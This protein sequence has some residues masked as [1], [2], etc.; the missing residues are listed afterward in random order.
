MYT[1]SYSG[2][3]EFAGKLQIILNEGTYKTTIQNI[4][5]LGW[6]SKFFNSADTSMLGHGCGISQYPQFYDII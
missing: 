2:I 5:N 4:H 3:S 1:F 6:K